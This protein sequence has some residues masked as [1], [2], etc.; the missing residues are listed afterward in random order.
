V[1]DKLPSDRLGVDVVWVPVVGEERDVP[2][3]MK[4]L[5]D[6]RARHYW[7]GRGL[8]VQAF[9]PVLALDEDAWDLYLVYKPGTRWEGA[10]PPAPDFWMHQLGPSAK[11]PRLDASALLRR[12][13]ADLNN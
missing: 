5:P 1:L 6:A 9:R 2:A 4:A 12:L 13:A 3:A 8:L 11:A 7:D 10:T